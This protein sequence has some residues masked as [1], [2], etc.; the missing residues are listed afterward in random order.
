MSGYRS[1]N[2]SYIL[3]II[4][5]FL[6]FNI[7]VKGENIHI[8]INGQDK[9]QELAPVV[10]D[11]VV[12]V[13]ARELARLFNAEINWQQSIKT[14]SIS[15]GQVLIK[16]M[17]GNPYIQVNNRTMRSKGSLLLLYGHTYL[18]IEDIAR[19]FGFLFNREGNN[20]YLSRPETFIRDIRWGKGGQAIVIEMDNIVPYRINNTNN[21]ARLELELEKAALADDFTDNISNKNFYLAVTPV[22]EEARLKISIISQYPIPFLGDRSIAEDGENLVINFL[23]YITGIRWKKDQLE[24]TASGQMARPEIMLLQEPRRLVIDIPDLM[25]S[26]FELE[27]DNNP[28]IKDVRVSQ[29]TYDPIVLR[30]V[31]ELYPDRYLHL[32]EDTVSS[33]KLVF[34]TT[35]RTSLTDL[36]FEGNGIR[37]ISDNKISPE[38]FKLKE[39]DRLVINILNADRGEGFRDRIDVNSELLKSIR[40][41]RFNEETIRIV[42]DLKQDIGYSLLERQLSDGRF[43]NIILFENSFKELLINDSE[44][45]TDLVLSFTGEVDYE[46][47]ESSG[48]LVLEV[49]GVKSAADYRVP[50][51][52]GVIKDIKVKPSTERGEGI[53]FEF[54]TGEYDNYK[55]FSSKPATSIT[56]SLMKGKIKDRKISNLILLDPGHGGFDPGAV[57]PSG[58]TEKDV[59]LAV[60]LLTAEILQREGYNVM[61]TRNDDRFISLK[62]RVEMANSLEA[63]LFVSIHS[64]S[65]NATYSEG[66]ETFIAPNKVAS[67]QLLADAL[68]Q[69]L[70]K[71]LKRYDRGVKKENFYVIKYTDMPAA[72]VE[73]AFI[74][75]PHEESLLASNLFREKA[76]RAIAQGIMEYMQKINNGS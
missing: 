43:M 27:L 38:I 49:S 62:D 9:S 61:L 2:L 56:L 72:L 15:D 35:E 39:P 41:S 24:I 37:F 6:F 31:L 65:A 59:N 69:N 22:A 40:T 46:I 60:A 76:A 52:L 64:N 45:K 70:L 14:L 33:G 55:V 7:V 34:N 73:V 8:H 68:Q 12:Y 3:I 1:R 47:K 26:D 71:E 74:S 20:I 32:L 75:N 13:K 50:A 44:L 21:P 19:C 16:M 36:A 25:L 11:N 28:W 23:P 30:V 42:A 10:Q 63:M 53:R 51:P 58:L 57:G 4:S 54:A 67:S 17:L 5:L 48:T 66:T 18:P 29:F